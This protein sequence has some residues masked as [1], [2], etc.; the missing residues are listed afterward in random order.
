MAQKTKVLVLGANGFIG[1]ALVRKLLE[2]ESLELFGL[3]LD[4]SRLED[5]I[6]HP[7]FHFR[8][9]DIYLSNE[10]IEYHVKKCDVVVSLVAVATPRVY[11]ENPLKVFQLDFEANL[12]IVKWVAKYGKR[13][14]FPSSS[15]VYGMCPDETFNEYSSPLVLGPVHESRWIYSCCKQLL[16]RVLVALGARGDLRYTLVRPFNW[17]GP[18]LDTL[19]LARE[20]NA[21]VI[22]VFISNL[23]RDDPLVLVGGGAQKRTFTYLSDGIEGLAGIIRTNDGVLDGKVFNLGNPANHISIQE[24]AEILV[25]E[26]D[27]LF[28]GK[29]TAGTEVQSPEEFYG[30]GYEDM[31]ARV[32]DIS[33]AEN[34]LGWHPKVG[35]RDAIRLTLEAFLR[36]EEL[37]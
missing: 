8:E 6:E 34:L 20:G 17:I 15:E 19:E 2:D 1:N 30:P 11:V 18:Q 16:D 25:E 7:G 26:Y 27:K 31:V 23:L 12:K 28:P 5:V 3:D 37:I 29:F 35:V 33:E 13:I 22:T 24:A 21:R 32:P 10:W 14:V 4:A 9:G 36:D